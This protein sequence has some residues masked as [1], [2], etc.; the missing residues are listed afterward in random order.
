MVA[1]DY[2]TVEDQGASIDPRTQAEI[3]DVIETTFVKDFEA[4][5]ETEM[6]RLENRWVAGDFAIEFTIEPSGLVSSAR[7]LEHDIKERRTLND[8]GEYATEGGAAPRPAENFTSC[9]E[10]KVYKW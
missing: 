7:M 1:T 4:C 6:S 5:L 3:Q 8:K 9:A 10:T 2:E